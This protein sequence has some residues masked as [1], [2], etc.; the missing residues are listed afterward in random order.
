MIDE[1]GNYFALAN[2]GLIYCLC[3][4]G[5]MEA[6]EESAKDLGIEPV[7]IANP[8]TAKLWQE[9]LNRQNPETETSLAD[10]DYILTDEAAWFTVG[11]KSV[12]IVKNDA[13]RILI[14]EIGHEMDE[15]IAQ[16][17]I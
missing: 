3:D 6:A 4:C 16:V 17:T 1:R 7:W 5:D 14:F 2:D 15:P 9:N 10:G 13:F 8:E 12:R 11:D